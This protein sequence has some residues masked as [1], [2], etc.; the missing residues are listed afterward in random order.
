MT[1]ACQFFFFSTHWPTV[2]SVLITT[3]LNFL[4][5]SPEKP[6]LLEYYSRSPLFHHLR[7]TGSYAPVTANDKAHSPRIE[8]HRYSENIPAQSSTSRAVSTST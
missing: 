2:P 3:D 8:C 7:G 4:L 6:N 5:T 1:P